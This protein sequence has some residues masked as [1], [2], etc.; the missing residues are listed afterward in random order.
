MQTVKSVKNRFFERKERV[1][2]KLLLY[3]GMKM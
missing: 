1:L 3:L 2:W